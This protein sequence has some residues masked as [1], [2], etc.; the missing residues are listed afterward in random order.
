MDGQKDGQ[1]ET[2]IYRHANLAGLLPMCQLLN[3]LP[4]DQSGIC[5]V[6]DQK[7]ELFSLSLLAA[8]IIE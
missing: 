2:R 8:I 3:F 4:N 7:I 5:L 1:M 6:R